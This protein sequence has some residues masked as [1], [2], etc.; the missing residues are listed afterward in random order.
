MAEGK[1]STKLYFE[2]FLVEVILKNETNRVWLFF[3]LW[4]MISLQR[5]ICMLL[6]WNSKL[7]WK[8]V[9]RETKDEIDSAQLVSDWVFIDFNYFG[10]FLLLLG[11]Q[12]LCY[13]LRLLGWLCINKRLKG[14]KR[15]VSLQ[16]LY[17]QPLLLLVFNL[18]NIEEQVLKFI[19]P[20]KLSQ[21]YFNLSKLLITFWVL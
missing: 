7:L 16:S 19:V 2:G 17:Y 10:L 14:F 15:I 6:V 8:S 13:C 12:E 18:E 4:L 21:S 1:N 5:Q 3:C 11:H 20:S 9:Q